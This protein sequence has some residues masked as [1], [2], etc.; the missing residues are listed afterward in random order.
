MWQNKGSVKVINQETQ[1]LKHIK[2]GLNSKNRTDFSELSQ[3]SAYTLEGLVYFLLDHCSCQGQVEPLGLDE[4]KEVKGEV[5]QLCL[6]LLTPWTIQS[7]EFSRP[8]YWSG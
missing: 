8:E 1:R 4:E 6:T 5:T 3:T 7:M 2:R